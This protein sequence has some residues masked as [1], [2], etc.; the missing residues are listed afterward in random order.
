[1]VGVGD[2]RWGERV[3]AVVELRAGASPTLEDVQSHCRSRIAGYKV[4]RQ[5][6]VVD[7]VQRSPSGK[8]DYPWAKATAGAVTPGAG[9]AQAAPAGTTTS[10]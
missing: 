10:T 6:C 4:P 9:P 7:R 1:V 8:P 5:L 2:E 3:V